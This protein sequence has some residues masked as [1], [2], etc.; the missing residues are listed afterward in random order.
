MAI[1]NRTVF[2]DL[3]SRAVAVFRVTTQGSVYLVGLHDEGGKK[4]VIVRGQGADHEV[5][6]V[7][8][9]EP[10]LGGRSLFDVPP[11][12]WVGKILE[13]ATMRSTPIES[14]VVEPEPAAVA[15]VGGEPAQSPWARPKVPQPTPA[16][17]S[18]ETQT[19]I[20]PPRGRRWSEPLPPF[21]P[22]T[23]R[24]VPQA[25]KGTL[26]IDQAAAL[27]HVVAPRVPAKPA[28]ANPA[29][30]P[31][32]E[33]E[34]PYPFRHLHYAESIV[35]LLRSIARRE[36]VFEDLAATSPAYRD[37]MRAALDEC[38]MLLETVRRRDR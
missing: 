9:T 13:V 22:E 37:R 23:P 19:L 38:A 1:G 28:P 21:V 24:I 17:G 35:Q 5:V 15:A 14:V 16:A 20:D 32:A 4:H 30:A 33:P 2:G 25:A 31:T 6:I 12:D 34:H 7:R 36:R 26:P 27:G 10:K 3:R 8:D 11:S 29:P 18:P